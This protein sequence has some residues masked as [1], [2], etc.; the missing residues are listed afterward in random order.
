MPLDRRSREPQVHHQSA[1]KSGRAES[2]IPHRRTE[3]THQQ[4]HTNRAPSTSQSSRVFRSRY[5]RAS[6]NNSA[7]AKPRRDPLGR[8]NL[9]LMVGQ[10][11]VQGP[12][13]LPKS[14]TVDVGEMTLGCFYTGSFHR[15][16]WSWCGLMPSETLGM[17]RCDSLLSGCGIA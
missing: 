11:R 10:E 5:F 9:P 13:L 3:E 17:K 7:S 1:F 8:D 15:G 14:C 6:H 2:S 4:R 12:S 16:Y